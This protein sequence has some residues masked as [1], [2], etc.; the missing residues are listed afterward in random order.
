MYRYTLVHSTL[1]VLMLVYVYLDV[2][3]TNKAERQQI[4]TIKRIEKL[5]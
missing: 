4:S 3:K 1:V 2:H 5:L